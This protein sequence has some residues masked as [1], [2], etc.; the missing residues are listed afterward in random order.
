MA[1]ARAR[2]PAAVGGPLR[3]L[4]SFCVWKAA[5]TTE[6]DTQGQLNAH[7]DKERVATLRRKDGGYDLV[8]TTTS[9]PWALSAARSA[10]AF[11]AEIPS[12]DVLSRMRLAGPAVAAERP[13]SAASSPLGSCSLEPTLF[14]ARRPT[15]SDLCNDPPDGIVF[16]LPRG[17]GGLL[18]WVSAQGRVSADRLLRMLVSCRAP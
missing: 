5:Q 10:T 6:A 3:G 4:S 7:G 8:V 12:V 14:P 17:C 11:N 18:A 13:C 16:L 9:L 15:N 2:W 1:L